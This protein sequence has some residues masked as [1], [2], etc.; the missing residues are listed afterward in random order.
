MTKIF[1][2][3]GASGYAPENTLPAF[4]MA[5]QQGLMELNLMY[6]LQKTG[7]LLSSMMRKSTEPVRTGDMCAIIRFRSLKTCHFTIR[8]NVIGGED[9]DAPGSAGT[10]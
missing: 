10:G 3:R 4:A 5:E 1:A 9:S 6:S 7:R 8:W 2:H